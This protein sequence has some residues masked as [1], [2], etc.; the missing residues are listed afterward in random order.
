MFLSSVDFKNSTR[1]PVTVTQSGSGIAGNMFSLTCSTTLTSPIPLPTNVPS[2]TFEWFFGLDGNASLPSSAT[3]MSN[4][5]DSTFTSILQFSPLSQSHAGNYI[6]RIG[7]GRLAN[8]TVV[9]VDGMS[10]NFFE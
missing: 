8:S 1:N 2:P 3:F 7:A 4:M 6:C 9:S 10:D 5:N